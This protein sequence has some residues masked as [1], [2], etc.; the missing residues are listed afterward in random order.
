[1]LLPQKAHQEISNPTEVLKILISNTQ[2]PS[3]LPVANIHLST[4]WGFD[5]IS[6]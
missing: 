3:P 4:P 6:D 2:R 5:A 1:M